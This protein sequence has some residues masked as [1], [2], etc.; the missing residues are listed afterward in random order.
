[1]NPI[2]TGVAVGLLTTVLTSCIYALV[3]R[4]TIKTRADSAIE[5]IRENLGELNSGQKLIFKLLLP[6]LLSA[7]DGKT[8]GELKE[9]LHLYNEYMQE[10]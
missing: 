5:E 9:A 4:L 6:L 10:K 8:N 1:M 2:F 3:R 7:R